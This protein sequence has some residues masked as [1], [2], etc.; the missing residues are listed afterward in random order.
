MQ[1]LLQGKQKS[2]QPK[3]KIHRSISKLLLNTNWINTKSLNKD[4]KNT[5]NNVSV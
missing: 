3:K 5:I 2:K 1:G 4:A